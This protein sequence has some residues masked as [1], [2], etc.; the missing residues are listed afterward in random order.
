MSFHKHHHLRISYALVRLNEC[1]VRGVKLVA[2]QG[3]SGRRVLR[4]G[5][6]LVDWSEQPTD[7]NE[8]SPDF[9]RHDVSVILGGTLVT[10][11]E[12]SLSRGKRIVKGERGGSINSASV[13]TGPGTRCMV[14]ESTM[15]HPS[16]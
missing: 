9:A 7:D 4:C 14:R 3:P 10:S 6:R 15:S 13:Q 11:E 2:A 8:L 16:R 1:E 5:S 12:G